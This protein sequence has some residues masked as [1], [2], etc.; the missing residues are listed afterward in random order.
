MRK[1][2]SR[3]FIAVLTAAALTASMG[4]SASTA[5]GSCKTD[6]FKITKRKNVSCR[7]AKKVTHRKVSGE[8][9]PDG[10]K[11]KN[12]GKLIPEG[13]CTKGTTRSFHYGM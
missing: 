1:R 11:C 10:W 4:V 5:A 12:T 13:N 6:G 8:K 3:T 2:I 7:T 9:L